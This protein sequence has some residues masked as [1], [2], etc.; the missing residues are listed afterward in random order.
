MCVSL[1]VVRFPR[2]LEPV[3]GE[4]PIWYGRLS[5]K[6][7]LGSLVAFFI[8]LLLAVLLGVILTIGPAIALF[9][10]IIDLIILIRALVRVSSTEYFISNYRVFVRYGII[11]RE[12]YEVRHEWI[13]NYTI[14]QGFMDRWLNRGDLVIGTP[15]HYKGYVEMRCVSNPIALKDLLENVLQKYRRWEDVRNKLRRLEEEFEFGRIDQSRYTELKNKYQE[16]LEKIW[17]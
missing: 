11:R 14:R 4:R 5:A 10:I 3:Q 1:F 2:F 17:D 9:L 12:I 15:G 6:C 16:E 8:I 7:V 13:S